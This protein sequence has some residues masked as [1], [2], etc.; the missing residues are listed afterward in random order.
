MYS[1]NIVN[2][3]EFTTILNAHTKKGLETYRMHLVWGDAW[4]V[5]SVRNKTVNG[6]E[7]K[8]VD[9]RRCGNCWSE[10]LWRLHCVYSW[11]RWSMSLV[12]SCKLCFT[13]KRLTC[14]WVTLLWV[15]LCFST[16]SGLSVTHR[17]SLVARHNCTAAHYPVYWKTHVEL[18]AGW[19]DTWS[20]I[21]ANLFQNFYSRI[22]S[23]M[24]VI[25]GRRNLFLRVC[26]IPSL[27]VVI[28]KGGWRSKKTKTPLA[29]TWRFL[30]AAWNKEFAF[31]LQ[32][33]WERKEVKRRNGVMRV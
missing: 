26:V 14:N 8:C 1:N 25:I 2:F 7:R 15:F 23:R 27:I 5:V 32:A 13:S 9:I 28:N 6:E 4:H 33:S 12:N 16:E 17:I 11:M 21:E 19:W 29:F 30:M 31:V 3:Q 18:N 10:I 22:G 20:Q 24:F